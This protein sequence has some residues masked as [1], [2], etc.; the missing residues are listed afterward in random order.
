MLCH[1]QIFNASRQIFTTISTILENVYNRNGKRLLFHFFFR[2]FVSAY[3]VLEFFNFITNAFLFLCHWFFFRVILLVF[4]LLSFCFFFIVQFLL[5]WNL[6]KVM[7]PPIACSTCMKLY[8]R[9]YFAYF[10]S[11]FILFF[12]WCFIWYNLAY[13]R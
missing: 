11:F 6:H 9:A 5:T 10:F 13:I 12:I 8:S 7:G 2:H 4:L 3:I 1:S